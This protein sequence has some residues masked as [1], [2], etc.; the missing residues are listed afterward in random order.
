M[1]AIVELEKYQVRTL[2]KHFELSD[3]PTEEELGQALMDLISEYDEIMDALGEEYNS[4]ID[5]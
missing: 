4:T 1:K 2:I 3:N 5:D